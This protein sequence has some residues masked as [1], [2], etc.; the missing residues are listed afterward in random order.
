MISKPKALAAALTGLMSSALM[1][2]ARADSTSVHVAGK[3]KY[4]TE[5]AVS[6]Y[7][8]CFYASMDACQQHNKS[9]NTR[10]IPNPNSGR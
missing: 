3:G 6:G 10:C 5:T 2:N 4:C 1:A 7:L 8:D 9:K